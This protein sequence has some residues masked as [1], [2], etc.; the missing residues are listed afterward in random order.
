[1]PDDENTGETGA[2][3][4]LGMIIGQ[5][6]AKMELDVA[7]DADAATVLQAILEKVSGGSG[8]AEDA[9]AEASEKL[10]GVFKL[11][12]DVGWDGIVKAAE[13]AIGKV[14]IDADSMKLM[15]EQLA[16]LQASEDTRA[17]DDAIAAQVKCGTLNPADA[18]QIAKHRK[19]IENVGVKAYSEHMDGAPQAI[20]PQGADGDGGA[21][22]KSDRDKVIKDS[23][24]DYRGSKQLQGLCSEQASVNDDLVTAGEHALTDDEAK[25]LGI[26]VG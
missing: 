10:R 26:A 7:L 16:A 14:D 17:A 22:P 25:K 13:G 15:S 1:M 24:A 18:N 5:I 21:E 2:G 20:P 11:A 23:R 8:E 9:V 4:D 12:A 19:L 3:P 6:V